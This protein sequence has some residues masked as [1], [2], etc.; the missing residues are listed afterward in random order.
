MRCKYC[1]TEL[2]PSAVRCWK[3]GRETPN[4]TDQVKAD[5]SA[6]REMEEKSA[7]KVVEPAAEKIGKKP[8]KH[9][10]LRRVVTIMLFAFGILLLCSGFLFGEGALLNNL[11]SLEDFGVPL[12]WPQFTLLATICLIG[13]RAVVMHFDGDFVTVSKHPILRRTLAIMS[14]I[15]VAPVAY[16]GILYGNDVESI[17]QE[18]M[19]LGIPMYPALVIIPVWLLA[20]FCLVMGHAAV[21]RNDRRK[22]RR[23]SRR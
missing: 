16:F 23:K 12:S 15:F 14:C 20:A 17:A 13:A 11:T 3:C 4:F 10:L 1:E 8:S 7:T 2:H 21:M 9:P 5:L 18:I 22:R 6:L 19:M